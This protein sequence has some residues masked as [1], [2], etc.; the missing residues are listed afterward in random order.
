MIKFKRNGGLG[1]GS[2][3]DRSKVHLMN[4]ENV[5]KFKRNC[6]FGFGRI[7]ENDWAQ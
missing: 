5:T 7:K 4:L 6:G 1:F 3:K 2:I